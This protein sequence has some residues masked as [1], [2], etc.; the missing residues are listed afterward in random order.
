MPRI[1]P[2]L[3]QGESDCGSACIATIL[4]YYGKT[5]SLRK[6]CE[7]AGTDR[8]GTSGLGLTRASQKFGM[9]CTGIMI[10]DKSKIQ[11]CP[12]PAIFHFKMETYEH[13]VVPYKVTKDKVYYCDPSVGITS[14]SIEEFNQKWTGIAFLMHPTS[15]FEEGS[16][17]KGFFSRFLVLLKPYKKYIIESFI[18]S[19]FL[20]FFGIFLSLYFRFLI[21][22]VLY[23]QIKS[24]LNLCSICYLFV[25]LMQV[26]LTYCRSQLLTY[27]GS[28][29]DVCLISDFY[30]HL[31]KLPLDFFLKRKTGEILSR[32]NDANV[33][34]N[35]ISSTLLSIAM[36]SVMIILGGVFMV[37]M[38]SVLLPVSMIPVLIS[39]IIVYVLRRPFKR[40]IK[41][42]AVTEAE[43]NAS[44]YEAINGIATIKGLATEDRAFLR[45]ER[46]VVE[47]AYRN[48]KLR[49]LGNLQ[50]GIQ[51]FVSSCG[52]LSIYWLGSFM[53]FKNQITLGQLIS[54]TTLSGYFLGPLSR[55]LTMQSYWQEVFVSAERL[56]DILDL[57]EEDDAQTKT[58]DADS[59]LGDIEFRNVCFSYGTRGR[60]INNVSLKIPAGKKV[61]FVGIS[62]SGKSTLLKL[63]MKFY[64]YEE[65]GIFINN[66]EITNYSNDSY[67]SRIG[68]VP[69]ESLLFSGTLRENIS[70]G[71]FDATPQRI[72]EAAVAS[73]AFP[74]INAL[75]DKFDTIVGEQGATLSGGER[76]RIALARILMRNPDIIILDEATASLDSISE[77]K[78][79]ETIYR[80][81]KDRTVIMVAHRLSTIRDCDCIFVFE[82]GE[83]VEQGTHKSLLSKKGKYSQM[84]KA[85]NEKNNYIETS[86]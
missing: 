13:Y 30:L 18:A 21:D 52:T 47:A 23:S 24:T 17:K 49:K 1:K 19:I 70:W 60:A 15:E 27:L 44:M 37:K 75:P 20:S 57:P 66:K 77:Q 40:L 59:V 45:T 7:A 38:G 36:D 16:D 41:D 11:S 4:N 26:L 34:R 3:Q 78:I 28:K 2:I 65:G 62:G 86:E 69:Q 12:L 33:I 80:Q 39:A 74:F 48:L 35:A 76:Q 31:L 83:L 84:W 9:S 82:H 72:L 61:A 50:N 22:E 64:H 63:L 32:I 29:I 68:Y 54:F 43:K 5:V 79:M 6:I 42:Q 10:T 51:T 14:D 67:R 73:Q 58:E 53:I 55:L 85:Q 25:V 8:A 46:K 56:S 71:C 81:I